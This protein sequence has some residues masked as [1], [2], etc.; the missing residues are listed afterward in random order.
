[1]V[2]IRYDS[3]TE[4]S[5]ALKDLSNMFVCIKYAD[6]CASITQGRAVYCGRYK[7]DYAQGITDLRPHPPLGA[8]RI[9]D[10][11]H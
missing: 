8:I 3:L 10:D 7:F 11:D 9:D 6:V 2:A 1:M 4:K 5:T